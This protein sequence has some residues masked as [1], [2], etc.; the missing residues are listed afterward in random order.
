MCGSFLVDPDVIP[1]LTSFAPCPWIQGQFDFGDI[2]P[3]QKSPVIV[4]NSQTDHYEIRL[5]PFGFKDVLFG[6]KTQIINARS[7]TVQEK[8]MFR[9]AMQTNRAIVVCSGFYEWDEHKQRFLF[10]DNRTLFLAAIILHDSFVI[11]TKA[12]N[13]SVSMVH[14]RMPVIFDENQA[15][16]WLTKPDSIGTLIN[17]ASPMLNTRSSFQQISLF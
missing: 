1:S 13:A 17:G 16:E 9:K 12:S 14:P 11:L 10:E 3:S 4:F 5:L 2:Y 6:K 15:K 7:E 8:R